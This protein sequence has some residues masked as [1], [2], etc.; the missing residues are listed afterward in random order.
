MAA[1]PSC[2]QSLIITKDK[3]PNLKFEEPHAVG[4]LKPRIEMCNLT[5]VQKLRA[6]VKLTKVLPRLFKTLRKKQ[7]HNMPWKSYS[8]LTEILQNLT[9]SYRIL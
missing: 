9:E 2:P 7:S 4:H 5:L 1:R 8:N 6:R 3:T